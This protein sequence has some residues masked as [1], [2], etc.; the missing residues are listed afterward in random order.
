MTSFNLNH[1]FKNSNTVSVV[2]SCKPKINQQMRVPSTL[3]GLLPALE[4]VVCGNLERHQEEEGT[5]AE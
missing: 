1:L 4:K 2:S 5:S 3:K